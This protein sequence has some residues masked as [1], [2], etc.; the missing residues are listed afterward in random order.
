[1]S[2]PPLLPIA[3]TT[4][5][6]PSNPPPAP[7][8]MNTFQFPEFMEAEPQDEPD[9]VLPKTDPIFQIDFTRPKTTLVDKKGKRC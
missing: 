5:L 9:F 2:P 4:D 6:R 8:E 7:R 3:L 1:M